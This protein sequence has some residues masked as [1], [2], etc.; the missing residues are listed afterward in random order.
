LPHFGYNRYD[1]KLRDKHEPYEILLQKPYTPKLSSCD[2]SGDY[3]FFTRADFQEWMDFEDP[4]YFCPEQ[5]RKE[6]RMDG[7]RG[8][9]LLLSGAAQ[10]GSNTEILYCIINIALNFI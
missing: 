4:D 9:G 3:T 6:V 8:P 2:P 10:E 5:H 1:A 7:L